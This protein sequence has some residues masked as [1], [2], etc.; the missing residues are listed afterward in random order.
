M[1]QKQVI[2]FGAADASCYNVWYTGVASTISS[3]MV[4]A[5]LYSMVGVAWTGAPWPGFRHSHAPGQGGGMAMLLCYLL[6]ASSP[7]PHH[8][9]QSSSFSSLCVHILF[10]WSLDHHLVPK[11]FSMGSFKPPQHNGPS[12]AAKKVCWL[13]RRGYRG[14][15]ERTLKMRSMLKSVFGQINGW[16]KCLINGLWICELPKQT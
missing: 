6:A 3:Y 2:R 10:W 5:M 13:A 8:H 9:C 4:W 14:R 12:G 16:V 1:V 7:T 11:L 15:Q